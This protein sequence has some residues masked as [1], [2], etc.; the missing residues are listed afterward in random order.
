MDWQRYMDSLPV[1]VACACKTQQN[2]KEGY[3][4]QKQDH[5]VSSSRNSI[6]QQI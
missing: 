5:K 3:P 4:Y 1:S 6:V 2:F